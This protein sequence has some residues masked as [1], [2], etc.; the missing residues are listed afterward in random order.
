ML[1]KQ[2][3]VTCNVCNQAVRIG[4]YPFCPH[5][6]IRRSHAQG[7]DPIV[8][9][10]SEDGA[11]RF[12][13]ATDALVPDGYRKI[14]IRTIQEADRVTREVNAREDFT[15][16]AVHAQSDAGRFAT[17]AK[18]REFID[19]IRHK[20]SPVARQYVDQAREYL[21]QKDAARENSRPR[22]TNFHMDVFSHDSSNREQHRDART[23]WRGRKG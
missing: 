5:E 19:S 13:A 1:D 17:R 15:L 12:P 18:N 22:S 3:E 16:R 4:D 23:D 9:H 6:S 11:Y 20:L 21:A 7:F 8:V 2:Q 14:E 10:V